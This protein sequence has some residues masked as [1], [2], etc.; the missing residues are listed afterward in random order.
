MENKACLECEQLF[1]HKKD[2]SNNMDITKCTGIN[3]PIKEQCRRFTAKDSERNQSY[4]AE[5]PIK[6]DKCVMY[7]GADNDGILQQLKNIMK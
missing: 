4:F 7:W 1:N 5:P 3:C 6:N 2:C